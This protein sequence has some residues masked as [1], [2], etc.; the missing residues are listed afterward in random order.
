MTDSEGYIHLH[1]GLRLHYR[2]I[3]DG[4]ETV[5]IPAKTWLAAELESLVRGRRLIFYDQRGRGQ[6]DVDKDKS[7]VWIDYDVQDIE[8]IPQHFRLDRLSLLGWSYMGAMVALYSAAH[9]SR[10]ERLILMCAIPPWSDAPYN[11][12]EARAKKVDERTDPDRIKQLEEMQKQG[13]EISASET[14]CREHNKVYLPRQMGRPNLLLECE[15]T[16]AR[17]QMNSQ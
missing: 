6:S 3:G 11:N 4:H 8:A 9:P 7:N 1:E 14:Y 13:F 10:V 2:V 5:M 16:P 12:P 17:L 15:V